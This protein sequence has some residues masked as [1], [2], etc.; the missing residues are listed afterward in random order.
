MWNI[1]TA[2]LPDPDVKVT[3]RLRPQRPATGG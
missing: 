2:M 1:K 3:L